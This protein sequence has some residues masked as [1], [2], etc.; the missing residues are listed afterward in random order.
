MKYLIINGSPRPKGTSQMLA[1]YF[2]TALKKMGH[3]V[4]VENL[5]RYIKDMSLL[6]MAVK[7]SECIVVIGPCY[8]ATYPAD[9][10][11]LLHQMQETPGV[12]HG[13]SLYGVIQ[14]GM[15]YVH[16]HESAIKMLEC[17]AE[18][19]D[20]IFKGGFVIGGG[21]V[22]NGQPL[23]K[24]IGAKRIVPAVHEFIQCISSD[25][26]SP[27]QLYRAAA[28]PMPEI[29]ARILAWA[30][31]RNLRKKFEQQGIDYKAPSPYLRK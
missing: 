4:K 17:Y 18:E 11:Y 25:K 13:Q 12:L 3:E 14:G 19:C 15:P 9:I 28:V 22:L 8:I 16:T 29:M 1:G 7:E 31:C 21:A 26:V 27:S 20:V 10:F 23:E 5:Y 24:V 30:M 2:F 6:L